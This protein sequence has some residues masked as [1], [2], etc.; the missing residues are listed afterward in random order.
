MLLQNLFLEPQALLW[1]PGTEMVRGGSRVPGGCGAQGGY[2][3]P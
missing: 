2:F 1:E 3:K